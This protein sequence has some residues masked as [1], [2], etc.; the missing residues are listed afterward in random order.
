MLVLIT[1]S[2]CGDDDDRVTQEMAQFRHACEARGGFA[3][4]KA[5]D[6]K[7]LQRICLQT[8]RIEE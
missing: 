6:G 3:L 8:I 5:Q 1:L 7:I 4:F 2:G